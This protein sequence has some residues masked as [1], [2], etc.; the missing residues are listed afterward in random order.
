MEVLCVP[1]PRHDS[2]RLCLGAHCLLHLSYVLPHSLSRVRFDSTL[3][4]TSHT[5][6]FSP[7]RATGEI[8]ERTTV[9]TLPIAFWQPPFCESAGPLCAQAKLHDQ[10]S[11]PR[12]PAH[13]SNLSDPDLPL[14]CRWDH[15][16][17]NSSYPGNGRGAHLL[18]PHR[19]CPALPRDRLRRHRRSVR[20]RP[21]RSRLRQQ[22]LVRN[23]RKRSRTHRR[24][25]RRDLRL[26]RN[27]QCEISTADLSPNGA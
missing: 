11:Q 25:C 5:P 22:R 18:L 6:M 1:L 27:R 9:H 2:I 20:R 4:P 12:F 8:Q 15:G 24:E 14:Q 26:P 13:N 17:R 3:N 21:R 7:T 19:L 23:R 16:T 10:P